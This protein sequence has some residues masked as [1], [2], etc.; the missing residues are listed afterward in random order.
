MASRFRFELQQQ[1]R[2]DWMRVGT[3]VRLGSGVPMAWLRGPT[4]VMSLQAFW[5]KWGS[6]FTVD[7]DGQVAVA[8][9]TAG[10]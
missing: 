2:H 9:S 6:L 10:L 3:D 4:P 1:L 8:C 5:T 7:D